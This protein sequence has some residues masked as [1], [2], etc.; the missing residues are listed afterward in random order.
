MFKSFLELGKKVGYHI[1]N[2]FEDG[3]GLNKERV[4]QMYEKGYSLLITVDNGIKAYE[5]ID[6]ANELGIDVIVID[7]HDYENCRMHVQS[8]IQ[9]C[10]RIIHLKKYVEVF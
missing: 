9:K 1:P 3:Y 6:L 10:H 4:Q 8:F 2:R 7:H 5:A